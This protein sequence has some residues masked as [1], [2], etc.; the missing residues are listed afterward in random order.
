MI[1]VS[2][3]A[4]LALVETAL[5]ITGRVVAGGLAP[6]PAEPGAIEADSLIACFG[7]SFVQGIGSSAPEQSFPAQLELMLNQRHPDCAVRVLNEGLAGYNSS[8]IFR[9]MEARLAE[10]PR[11]PDLILVLG[12]NNNTWNLHRCSALVQGYAELPGDKRWLDHLGRT[13][14]G[15]FVL[16]MRLG[17]VPFGR[18]LAEI[19][20]STW[21][22]IQ[23]PS[24]QEILNPKRRA[25]REFLHAWLLNDMRS[26]SELAEAVGSS[27]AFSMPTNSYMNGL[28][29][30]CAFELGLNLYDTPGDEALWLFYGWISSDGWHPNDRGY[31][32]YAAHIVDS[33]EALGPTA[34][35]QCPG[36]GAKQPLRLID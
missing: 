5:L 13:R 31:S 2:F 10:Y 22:D 25:D 12:F 23:G 1:L 24:P 33:I 27:V 17:D 6:D 29:R 4:V 28:V 7:A 19:D 14:I 11:M 21:H 26:M 9:H 20:E 36:E 30:E 3:I 15:R 34:I 18:Q 8:D 35:L 32:V 16:L